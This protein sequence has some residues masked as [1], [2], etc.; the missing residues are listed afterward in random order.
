MPEKFL[1]IVGPNGSGKSSLLKILS[2]L[3]PVGEGDVLLGGVSLQKRSQTD[4]ARIDRGC[5]A[6]VRASISIYRGRD[7]VDGTVSASGRA[8]VEHGNRR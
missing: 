6:G 1:G 3:L 7:G 5:A 2:G 4:I 8:M